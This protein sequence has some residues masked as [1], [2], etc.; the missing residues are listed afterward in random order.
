M[1]TKLKSV[2]FLCVLLYVLSC[3]AVSQEKEPTTS[4]GLILKA[5]VVHEAQ[6]SRGSPLIMVTFTNSSTN[7]FALLNHFAYAAIGPVLALQPLDFS[8]KRAFREYI[9]QKQLSK[10]RASP[11]WIILKPNGTYIFTSR[12]SNRLPAG[13]SQLRVSYM[14][15]ENARAMIEECRKDPKAPKTFWQGHVFSNV[16]EVK[17]KKIPTRE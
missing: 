12:V 10:L 16:I 4:A 11:K 5:E 2:A 7:T 14:V 9:F 6:P 13:Q 17:K 8:A 15:G 3:D 1:K